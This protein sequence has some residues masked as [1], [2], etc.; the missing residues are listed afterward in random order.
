MIS[1][2]NDGEVSLTEKADVRLE[3]EE[4]QIEK[5]DFIV[6]EGWQWIIVIFGILFILILINA[7][8]ANYQY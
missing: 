2:N 4:I 3:N 1:I 8:F 7:S 5:D 6:V